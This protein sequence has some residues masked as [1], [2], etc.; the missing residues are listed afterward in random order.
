MVMFH[1]EPGAQVA[2]IGATSI[3]DAE[4]VTAGRFEVTSLAHEQTATIGYGSGHGADRQTYQQ[5]GVT[6]IGLRQIGI[7][8]P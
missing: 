5:D 2:D 6:V 8:K 1:L 4:V 7:I 3:T